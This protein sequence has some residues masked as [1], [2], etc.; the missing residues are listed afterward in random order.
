MSLHPQLQ[1]F[2]LKEIVSVAGHPSEGDNKKLVIIATHSTEMIRIERPEDLLSLVFCYDLNSDPVQI[3]A[4]AGELK[5][6]KIQGLIARLGQEHKLSLFSRRPLLV[7]GPSDVMIC[8]AL[9]SKAD[10]HLEAAGSQLLPEI[11]K[12]Q[13]PIVAKLLRLL[14]KDPV[15]LAD[16]DGVADGLD[17]VNQFLSHNEI[18]DREAA[19]SGFESASKMIL[20]ILFPLSSSIHRGFLKKCILCKKA[21]CNQPLTMSMGI[22]VSLWITP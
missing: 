12:G 8:S 18:A 3:P 20:F 7:E 15:S 22:L 9:A 1:A 10:M 5:N 21:I 19:E 4:E 14:G 6:A 16:A 13:M 11:G 17:L 2:L